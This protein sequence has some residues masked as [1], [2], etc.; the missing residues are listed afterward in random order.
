MQAF[1][2]ERQS[3]WFEGMEAAFRYFGGVPR[4]VLLDNARALV[5]RHDAATREVVFNARLHAFA[6]YW[7]FRP[8]ACAPYRARTKGKDE[9]EVGYVKGNA[10][11]GHSFASWAALEGHLGWWMREI[12]D[13]HVHGTTDEPPIE[14]F[15]SAERAALRAVDGRPPFGQMRQLV[16]RV[17]SDCAIELDSNAYSVPW[18]L[19][20]ETVEVVVGGGRVSIRHRGDEVAAHSETAGRHQRVLDPAHLVGIGRPEPCG[21]AAIREGYSVLFTAAPALIAALVRAHADGYLEERLGLYAKPRHYAPTT[22]E[23]DLP[24]TVTKFAR[25][26]NSGSTT[27]SDIEPILAD[28]GY[29]ATTRPQHTGSGSI[30]HVRSN[31]ELRRRPGIEEA[32]LPRNRTRRAEPPSWTVPAKAPVSGLSEYSAVEYPSVELVPSNPWPGG[33]QG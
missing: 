18:R 4:E 33:R 12:A 25:R 5:E 16:R 26:Q 23:C 14:R 17:Q 13:K 28:A 30:P 19:I 11:A 29:E 24:R 7:G 1:C 3:A 2:H 22:G 10:I 20:G 15:A 6:R 8:R 32:G 31:R 9:R 21:R 27:G